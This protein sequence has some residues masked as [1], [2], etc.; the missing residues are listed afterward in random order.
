MGK[1]DKYICTTLEKRYRL[2]GPT[3]E[4]RDRLAA[5]GKRIGMEHLHWIDEDVIPGAYYGESTWIWP[6]D[7]P[8]QV[9]WEDLTK[10]GFQVPDMFPHVHDFPELLSWWGTNPNDF[11]DTDPLALQLEDEIIPAT[12]S[13]VAY[14][15]ANMPHMPIFP[16][17][18]QIFSRPTLHWVTGP[19]GV[20]VRD[21]DE[22][23]KMIL[24]TA[25][26]VGVNE[27][28]YARYIIQ[29]TPSDVRR[30]DFMCPLDP[31]YSRPMAYIDQMVIPEAEFG[32]DTRWLLPGGGSNASHF[33]MDAHTVPYGTS[34]ACTCLNYDDITDL[35]AEV[36]LWI[37]GEK[38]II[39]KAFWAYV[40]PNLLQ[41]P[42]I[43]RNV[44]KQMFFM[45]S[46]PIGKGVER[47][48]GG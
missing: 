40:P 21:K 14:I 18:V 6:P 41:G 45:T 15:P 22:S 39:T 29:G 44:T 2:P 34:I 1:Y 42:M 5:D 8:N 13:F 16:T 11:G 48:R 10:V 12:S 36:E 43:I 19:G 46:W 47:Y 28:K 17:G 32:C 7:Y 26:E 3:P 9:T 27:S 35:C 33:I 38:H 37:G 30:P 23:E 20:Y 25:R 31:E 24:P 4:Q